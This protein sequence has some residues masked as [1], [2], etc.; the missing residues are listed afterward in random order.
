M[1]DQVNLRCFLCPELNI[2]DLQLFNLPQVSNLRE[3]KHTHLEVISNSG[4]HLDLTLQPLNAIVAAPCI[5][6]LSIHFQDL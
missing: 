5:G 4:A 2:R 3:V 1:S 6:S